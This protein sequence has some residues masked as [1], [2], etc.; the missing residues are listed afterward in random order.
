[1]T[2]LIKND[3]TFEIILPFFW[4]SHPAVINSARMSIPTA[5][6]QVCIHSE[7]ILDEGLGKDW[8][9][10][11]PWLKRLYHSHYTRVIHLKWIMVLLEWAAIN[12]ARTNWRFVLNTDEVKVVKGLKYQSL[13]LS[14]NSCKDNADDH[15]WEE[16]EKCLRRRRNLWSGYAAGVKETWTTSV[17]NH[18]TLKLFSQ[19]RSSCDRCSNLC[20][21]RVVHIANA[22]WGGS[23]GGGCFEALHVVNIYVIWLAYMNVRAF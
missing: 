3:S 8:S 4:E 16:F 10:I 12:F 17:T 23:N 9:K 11:V 1:M 6:R 21:T 13:Q 19:L 14:A 5:P 22:T 2:Q 15:R 20:V 18:W 7:T